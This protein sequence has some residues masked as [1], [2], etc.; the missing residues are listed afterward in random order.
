MF[1]QDFKAQPKN[2]QD[3]RPTT[4]KPQ[5]FRNI[6]P[7]QNNDVFEIQ[8]SISIPADNN[9]FFINENT[10][11]FVSKAQLGIAHSRRQEVRYEPTPAEKILQHNPTEPTVYQDQGS[12]LYNQQQQVEVQPPPLLSPQHQHVLAQPILV[13]QQQQVYQ[14]QP[15]QTDH[16]FVQQPSNIYEQRATN[17]FGTIFDQQ[18]V[19]ANI[20]HTPESGHG[21]YSRFVINRS[22]GKGGYF[23][24][25]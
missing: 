22:I 8:K 23:H 12:L 7:V 25:Y 18:N 17:H 20:N 1:Y 3:I 13:P 14:Q 5:Y 16:H 9:E 15:V 11:D 6:Q 4:Y 10:G 2:L 19:E 24:Q 21:S